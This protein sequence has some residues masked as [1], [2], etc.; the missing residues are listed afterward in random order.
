M[1]NSMALLIPGMWKLR[2]GKVGELIQSL[3][4][5]EEMRLEF[6]PRQTIPETLVL[7]TTPYSLLMNSSFMHLRSN[8]EEKLSISTL[9]SSSSENHLK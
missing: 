8:T 2:S 4:A 7:T 1:I 5:S 9:K 3:P 6:K